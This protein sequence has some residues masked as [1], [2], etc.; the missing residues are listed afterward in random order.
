MKHLPVVCLILFMFIGLSVQAQDKAEVKAEIEK[1]NNEIT[2][3]MR[4]KKFEE[5]GAYFAPDLI[6]MVSGQPPITSRA[7]WIATQQ[8]GAQIGDWDLQLE[9]LD[10]DFSG[11]MVVERGRGTNTFTANDKSPMPSFSMTGDYMVLWKKV[12][13][14]WMIQ[15]DYVVIHQPAE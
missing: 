3:L 5:A 11:D 9:V 1:I 4:A 13:G 6:Q 7:A 15:W 12:D 14:K 2:S 10:V 8:G